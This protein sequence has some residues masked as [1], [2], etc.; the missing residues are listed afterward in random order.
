MPTSHVPILSAT[1]ADLAYPRQP[2][3]C[4]QSKKRL[5][6]RQPGLRPFLRR[7]CADCDCA[8]PCAT[9]AR[10][11]SHRASSPSNRRNVEARPAPV[12]AGYA[13]MPCHAVAAQ[14][15]SAN[16][17]WETLHVLDLEPRAARVWLCTLQITAHV[18]VDLQRQVSGRWV[19][20]SVQLHGRS[21]LITN[22]RIG[23]SHVTVYSNSEPFLLGNC[24]E[25][26]AGRVTR[27]LDP[28]NTRAHLPPRYSSPR[29]QM[30][31]RTPM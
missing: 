7:V 27:L 4:L 19:R 26:A 5:K 23:S 18:G 8:P 16:V 29:Q 31:T 2:G 13:C 20:T 15:E 28:E 25:S 30:G 1:S 10:K 9:W 12:E 17:A 6:T 3:R 22:T 24:T 11:L 21:S 14:P